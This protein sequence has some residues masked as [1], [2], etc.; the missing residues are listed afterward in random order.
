MYPMLKIRRKAPANCSLTLTIHDHLKTN[1]A[2]MADISV[3]ISKHNVLQRL[4]KYVS[5]TASD[6]CIGPKRFL[7]VNKVLDMMFCKIIAK[8]R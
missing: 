1:N 5:N 6:G 4:V 8:H 7:Q 3:S 2:L